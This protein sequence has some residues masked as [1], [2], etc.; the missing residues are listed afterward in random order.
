MA[1][2]FYNAEHEAFRDTVRRFVEREIT[3][4]GARW[5]EDGSFP[6]DLYAK[7]ANAGLFALNF[8]EEFGGVAAD[9]F[10]Y[11]I[12][13]QE[14]ARACAGGVVSGLMTHN[15]GAPAIV[16]LGS[17]EQKQRYLPDILAGRKIS[18]LAVTEPSGGSDVAA[19]RTTAVRNGDHYIVNGQKTFITSGI[20]ADFLTVAV[21][22]GGPGINGIS[23]L[24]I[25]G[26]SPGLTRTP[27]KKMGWW[28]S[29]TAELHFDDVKVPVA[30]RLGEENSGFRA[31]MEVFNSERLWMAAQSTAYAQICLE[32]AV[33]W[34][35]QRSVFGGP[36]IGQQVIRHKLVDMAMRI[37][38]SQA[39]VEM[40]AWRMNEGEKIGGEIAM[41][42]NQAT[43]TYAYCASE[44][45]QIHGGMG[46]MRGVTVE[47]L[48]RDVKVNAIGGGAEEVMKELAARQAGWM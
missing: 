44:A 9:R 15:I 3:P 2:P 42:K 28:A 7:A 21:R 37:N 17:E 40:L 38:A 23:I 12:L 41:A 18:A 24:V 27:L 10:F 36:L 32:E 4:N 39:L 26:E 45:V 29:D 33:S 48:Y 46:F 8:P 35:K 20:R 5:E 47:R 34:A 43:Q 16:A 22:T 1:H 30:N 31:V 11:I 6:R 25:D 13:A 14:L 19:L